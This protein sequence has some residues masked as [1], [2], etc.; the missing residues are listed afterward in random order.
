MNFSQ[1]VNT[2][3]VFS[4]TIYEG[5]LFNC[6]TFLLDLLGIE[7]MN[8]LVDNNYVKKIKYIGEFIDSIG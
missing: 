4:T 6:K 2:I 8:S 1:K 7:Y 5:L 3:G